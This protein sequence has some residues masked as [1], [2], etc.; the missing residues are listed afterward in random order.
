MEIWLAR[1]GATEW[2]RSG[3]H[4][5]S[6]DLA[7]LPEGARQATAMR[8]RLAEVRFSAVMTSPLL[9]AVQTATRISRPHGLTAQPVQEL[10][11]CDLGRWEG[12]S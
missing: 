8:S 2:S 12:L 4:T 9:R 11:E 1:H 3:R 10:T 5:G 6:T 7:L